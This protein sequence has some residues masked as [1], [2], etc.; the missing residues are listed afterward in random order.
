MMVNNTRRTRRYSGLKD[1]LTGEVV[2][3]EEG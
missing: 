3:D 1:F 2:F